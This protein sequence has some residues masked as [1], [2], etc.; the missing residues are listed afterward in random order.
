MPSIQLKVTRYA[1]KQENV[2]HSQG[3][4]RSIKTDPKMA[5]IL[6]LADLADKKFKAAVIN[7]SKK[8]YIYSLKEGTAKKSQE[9]NG[10]Y[11]KN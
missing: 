11:K 9:R 10:N 7:I 4:K 2:T 5:Q 1:K 6:D 3:G 8:I